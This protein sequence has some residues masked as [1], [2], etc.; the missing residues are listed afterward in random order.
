M[1]LRCTTSCNPVVC[2][3]T[4]VVLGLV[5]LKFVAVSFTETV[6]SS[7]PI[8]TVA[9]AKLL[10]GEETST[11]VLGSLFPIMAGLA[12]TSAYEL[13]F[14]IQGFL[15]ALGTNITEW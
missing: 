4:T 5:A 10:L 11:L 8:F 14:N 12:L 3:F 7:A 13:S 15:A 1:T 2:R 9:I 6:K